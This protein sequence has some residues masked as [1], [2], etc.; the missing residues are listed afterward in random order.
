M[1]AKFALELVNEIINDCESRANSNVRLK[2][3]TA[4]L[5]KLAAELTVESDK[6]AIRKHYGK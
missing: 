4:S 1:F 3:A 6:E 5:K 2:K